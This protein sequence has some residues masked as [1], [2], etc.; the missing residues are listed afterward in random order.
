MNQNLTTKSQEAL[1]D[2]HKLAQEHKNSQI[3]V[4]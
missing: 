3:G 4:R 1:A 2:A